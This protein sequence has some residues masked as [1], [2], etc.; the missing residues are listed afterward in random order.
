MC[1]KDKKSEVFRYLRKP[2]VNFFVNLKKK[3]IVVEPSDSNN[4]QFKF[5]ASKDTMVTF[6]NVSKNQDQKK[7][8]T[9]CSGP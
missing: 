9:M 2:K 1:S 7:V 5:A 3:D 8:T 6:S 4:V